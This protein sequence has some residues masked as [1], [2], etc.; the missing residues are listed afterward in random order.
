MRRFIS[1]CSAVILVASLTTQTVA[2]AEF[3]EPQQP[4]EIDAVEVTPEATPLVATEEP[5]ATSETS[6][7]EEIV[8]S[9]VSEEIPLSTVPEVQAL[10]SEPSEVPQSLDELPVSTRLSPFITEV[11]VNGTC[12]K[13]DGTPCDKSVCSTDAEFIELFNPYDEPVSLAG[14]R[15]NYSRANTTTAKVTMMDLDAVMMQPGQVVIIGCNMPNVAMPLAADLVATGGA[16]FIDDAQGTIYDQVAWGDATRYFYTKQAAKP[17]RDTSLQRCF[18]DGLLEVFESRNTSLEFT[19]YPGAPTPGDH[20]ACPG[21][22]TV[23]PAEPVNYC[24]GLVLSEIAANVD[25]QFIELH[26]QSDVVVDMTGCMVQT[27]RSAAKHV[28][29][30]APLEAGA[31]KVVVIRDTSP[32]LT[33]TKT[34]VGSVYL[35]A[36]DGETEIDVQEYRNLASGTAW[37]RFGNEWQQTYAVTPGFSNVRQLFVPC[38]EGY[39]RNETTGRCNKIAESAALADCGDGKYRSE[40]TGRCRNIPQESMLAACKLGQYRSEETNR[41]RNLVTASVLKPCRDDQYRSE[42][43]NRCRNIATTTSTLKPCKDNQ[44]RSEE[45]N[46]CRN[47]QASAPPAAAYAVEPIKQGALGFVGWWALGGVLMCAFGYAAWEWRSEI[48][49]GLNRA[50]NLLR[51]K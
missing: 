17:I 1:F 39:V 16:L 28:L 30:A 19:V 9:P 14:L 24:D 36:S 21:R 37:A 46:R 42:E 18:V 22:G 43:T 13:A 45:T 3:I 15:L 33:L 31:Y 32:Q 29:S 47:I 38:A 27:N 40:E 48:R 25:D 44:Y 5:L 7:T 49:R 34:T 35:L 23:D 26:N 41:C 50:T 6:L 11:S 20:M 4:V 10:V 2:A 12:T 8:A 51:R